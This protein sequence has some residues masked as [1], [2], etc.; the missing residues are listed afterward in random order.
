MS[1]FGSRSARLMISTGLPC[2]SSSRAVPR[3]IFALWAVFNFGALPLPLP[4]HH[5]QLQFDPDSTRFA[6][7]FEGP[8]W[9][10]QDHTTLQS[11]LRWYHHSIGDDQTRRSATDDWHCHWVRLC[12]EDDFLG[13]A[14]FTLLSDDTTSSLPPAHPCCLD[15]L[16]ILTNQSGSN[17]LHVERASLFDRLSFCDLLL[18][19][20]FHSPISADFWFDHATPSW[21]SSPARC[22]G[23]WARWNC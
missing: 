3:L 20:S 15:H 1:R 8:L 14:P 10:A 2:H 13:N 21:S 9:N 17:W 12:S 6:S 7:R 22:R 4:H 5:T 11:H 19:T 18:L 23:W 16:A